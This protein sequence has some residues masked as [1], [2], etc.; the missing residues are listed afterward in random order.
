[1]KGTS[2]SA[3]RERNR[4]TSHTG[5]AAL[6]VAASG[7]ATGLYVSL[8]FGVPPLPGGILSVV[9]VPALFSG[10]LWG[11][12]RT[13]YRTMGE[14][15]QWRAAAPFLAFLIPAFFIPDYLIGT[16]ASPGM[17]AAIIST[18]LACFASL[19]CLMFGERG[20]RAV[21]MLS[22]R[23]RGIAIAATALFIAALVA[24]GITRY[25]SFGFPG[26]DLACFVQSFWAALRGRLFWNTHD[27][28]Q[29]GSHFGKHFSPIMFFILPVYAL[30]PHGITLIALNAA[31][32]GLGALVVYALAKDAIGGYAG[33]CFSLCYLM[34]PGIDYAAWHLCFMMDYAPLFLLLAL[35]F[36]RKERL[37]PFTM[38][39]VISCSVREDVVLT[40]AVFGLYALVQGRNRAWIL[41]P[42]ILCAAWFALAV[43]VIIPSLGPGSIAEF[44]ADTGGSIGGIAKAVIFSP[45][46][47]LRRFLAPDYIRLLYR[48]L[49]PLALFLPLMSG[50]V[51]FVVP[52]LVIIGLSSMDQTRYISGYYY[53]PLIPFLFAAAMSAVRK[54]SAGD[55][56]KAR[57]LC[58]I[59]LFLAVSV[60]VRGFLS[61]T[62]ERG[63]TRPYNVR[64][65]KPYN[66]VLRRAL[67]VVPPDESVFCPRYMMPF[68]AERYFV[69]EK[70][71]DDARYLI[72]DARSEDPPTR[73]ILG[74][75]L[76]A[77]IDR[78]PA[79]T[80]LFDEEGVRV[81]RRRVS[82]RGR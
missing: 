59:L 53:M 43:W 72:I 61:E 69:W 19:G 44:Y 3:L 21:E 22:R 31:A 48:I 49:T 37:G 77:T 57:V 28:F 39:L 67:E 64:A 41:I 36:Y 54:I 38:A 29:G 81:Y 62:M 12:W 51:M 82:E 52:S 27:V 7:G 16:G 56:E 78:N 30:A 47:V 14:R 35:Y 25:Y 11:A 9:W 42:A 45:V 13:I 60:F 46:A 2:G 24:Y 70:V 34:Y 65:Q 15:A 5:S 75:R 6:C 18:A 4:R 76:L 8:A 50:E 55:G 79:Y 74:H 66:A 40:A 33:L 80:K 63:I 32:L 23:S 20:E 68:L 10:A 17:A 26:A 1:M 73:V 58:T 71:P